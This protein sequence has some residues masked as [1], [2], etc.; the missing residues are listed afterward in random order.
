MLCSYVLQKCDAFEK[1]VN[2]LVEARKKKG[3]PRETAIDLLRD[4]VNAFGVMM[5]AMG[6]AGGM[7]SG[8]CHTTAATIRPAMQVLRTPSLVSSCFFMCL[9]DKVREEGG[10][11]REGVGGRAVYL[12]HVPA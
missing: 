9:P 10:R 1:Y 5:V 3:L 8:A 11:G 4:D 6:D 2:G 7:V 12:L